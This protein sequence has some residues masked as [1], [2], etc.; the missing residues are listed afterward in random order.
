MGLLMP[1]SNDPKKDREIFLKILTMDEDGL[2][3]RKNKNLTIKELAD[4]LTP[5]ERKKFIDDSGKRVTFKKGVSK[6]EKDYLHE[7]TFNRL[8]H[9]EKLKLCLR[10]EGAPELPAKA[11]VTINSH[12][13]TSAKN[14]QELIRELGEKR[15]GH[16]PVVGDCFS[17]G[18]SIPFEAARMGANVFASDLNPIAVLLTWSA[19]NLSR[20]TEEER[21]ELIDFQSKVFSAADKQI[22]DWGIEHNAMGDR[23]I[24][25]LYCNETVC[26]EPSCGYSVPLAPSWIIGQPS[27]TVAVLKEDDVGKRFD[28][29]IITNASKEEMALAESQAT[30]IDTNF[31]CPKCG[32]VNSIASLRKT[33]RPDGSFTEGLRKWEADEFLPS[34]LDVFQERLY[35]IRYEHEY[36]GEDG[37]MKIKR[38]YQ[39]PDK[40][41]LEREARVVELLTERF[42]RWQL[43]GFLPTSRIE[44]GLE[45]SRLV[46]ER[47]WTHWHQLFNPRQLLVGG[48]LMELIDSYARNP[49]QKM[50]GLLSINR[51]CDWNARLSRW[52][53]DDSHPNTNVFYNQALNPLF[54]YG[55]R[56]FPCYNS[57]FFTEIK[58]TPF[59]GES[60]VHPIDARNISHMCDIWIT[61]PPYADAV[62]YHELSEFFL[63]WN[64]TVLRE[65]FP[66]W[67]TDSKRALAVKGSGSDFNQS[68]VDVYRRLRTHMPE[69]GIQIVMFTHQDVGVWADLT[70]IL[71]ASGLRVTAAWNIA[72]ET[73]SGGLK[74]GNYVKGTVLLVL[75]KQDTDD[76]AYLDELYPEIEEEVRSQIDSMRGLDDKEEPNFSDADY[77]LAAYAASLKVLTSYKQIEDIDVAYELSKERKSGD[78][79][80]IEQIINQAVKIAYDY[81]T[82]SGFDSYSWKL[83]T[84]EERF[85]VKGLD[86]ETDGIKQIGA[87]QELAR[88]FGVSDY[89]ELLASTRANQARLKTASEYAMRGIGGSGGFAAS[90]LRNILAAL[91]QCIRA[92]NTLSGKNW[93]RNEVTDYWNQRTLIMELLDFIAAL[94]EFDDMEH[95]KEEAHYA[96][97]LRELVKNDGV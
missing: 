46:R 51:C 26:P 39:A 58:Q 68:M 12:L 52:I 59:M 40:G 21:Q 38:Y 90:L 55:C 72:T 56:A 19:L 34:P 15:F 81:L 17:G 86:F 20:G 75:R 88:G 43:K 41:D 96:R 28:I 61:D 9:D 54:D 84:A 18:G 76:T 31:V 83:L 53:T 60:H 70:M 62:N 3:L 95:W 47:G 92:E 33:R 4:L 16:S 30:I 91:Y 22:T 79:S 8:S 48:L 36:E 27:R 11:W 6:V 35:C 67:Y 64:D 80:P 32:E 94:G 73:E 69:H 42:S 7:L 25:Y 85:F 57:V 87:Y 10:P 93:L 74:E 24:S 2:L 49:M 65:V 71:W 82:P 45:T 89:K 63:A 23:A 13:G 37:K 50:V 1:V 5:S 29:N 78:E 66:D 97:M 14:L 44:E 77:L